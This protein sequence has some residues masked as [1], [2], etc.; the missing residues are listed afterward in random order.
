MLFKGTML[1]LYMAI[2]PA[3]VVLARKLAL[4]RVEGVLV[5]TVTGVDVL[6]S[7][8]TKPSEPS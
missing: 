1:M 7:C 6:L 8:A 3:P 4:L 2:C 5:I